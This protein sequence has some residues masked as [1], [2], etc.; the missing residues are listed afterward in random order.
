MGEKIIT[1]E[2]DDQ[3]NSSLDL[4]GFQGKGCGDVADVFRG[5]DSLVVD[6]QKRDYHVLTSEGHKILNAKQG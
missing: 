1:I 2:I 3:G 5:A 6:R 4:K